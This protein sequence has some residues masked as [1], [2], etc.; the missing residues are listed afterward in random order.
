MPHSIEKALRR[1]FEQVHHTVK[2]LDT[3]FIS[4]MV[5]WRE[6][7]QPTGLPPGFK[8]VFRGGVIKFFPAYSPSDSSMTLSNRSFM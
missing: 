6:K 7:V 4:E 2:L 3:P 8:N 1:Q 5:L